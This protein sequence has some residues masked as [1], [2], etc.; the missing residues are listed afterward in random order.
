[1]TGLSLSSS[2]VDANISTLRMSQAS[3]RAIEPQPPSGPTFE[4]ERRSCKVPSAY[5]AVTLTEFRGDDFSF[6]TCPVEQR[7]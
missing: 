2:F 4:T 5:Q 6:P 1:M 3:R 7:R